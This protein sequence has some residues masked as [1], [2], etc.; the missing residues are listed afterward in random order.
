MT[1]IV[2]LQSLLTIAKGLSLRAHVNQKYGKYNYFSYH[3]EGVAQ[4]VNAARMVQGECM[5]NRE[6]YIKALIVA[7][8]HDAVEDS[9]LTLEKLRELCFPEDVVKAIELVTKTDE[10]VIDDYLVAIREN[11]IALIVKKADMTFNMTNTILEKNKRKF[12]KYARQMSILL[13]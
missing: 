5:F 8:L 1:R 13:G 10:T 9:D 11:E 7:Y 4:G 3:I 2:K 12:E 6:T